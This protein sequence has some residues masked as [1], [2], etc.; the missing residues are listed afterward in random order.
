MGPGGLPRAQRAPVASSSGADLRSGEKVL[1]AAQT[2]WGHARDA[3]GDRS[4]SHSRLTGDGLFWLTQHRFHRAS[5]SDRPSWNSCSRS[6]HL[7]HSTA[8]SIPAGPSRVVAGVLSLCSSPPIAAGGAC[9]AARARGQIGGATLPTTDAGDG[10]RQ[11][12]PTMDG[13][14]GARLPIAKGFRLRGIAARW[15]CRI[16]SR[17][18]AACASSRTR[19]KA[20]LWEELAFPDCPLP[21]IHPNMG[22]E[23]LVDLS[24]ISNRSTLPRALCFEQVPQC[25]VADY[26]DPPLC[27]TFSENE[28]RM[29]N[30]RS[31]CAGLRAKSVG[32]SRHVPPGKKVGKDGS[33]RRISRVSA[34]SFENGSAG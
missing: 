29:F 16:L 8:I 17:E 19:V 6:T 33:H 13:A 1:P 3:A 24:T 20:S 22:M 28:S 10:S 27:A 12:Q 18:A 14:R 2:D 30:I 4:L 23:R 31:T 34:P 15:R 7:G 25:T 21:I 9:A 11:N 32:V 5:Q 26:R